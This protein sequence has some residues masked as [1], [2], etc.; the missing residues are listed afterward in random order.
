MAAPDSA[1]VAVG[2]DSSTDVAAL[3]FERRCDSP[4]PSGV[5][6][7]VPIP[8]TNEGRGSDR[9]QLLEKKEE[10]E[11]CFAGSRYA[12]EDGL[13]LSWQG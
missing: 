6:V 2:N 11:W 3:V 13:Y 5:A 12:D 8:L 9:Q 4:T 7:P 1:R 10:E